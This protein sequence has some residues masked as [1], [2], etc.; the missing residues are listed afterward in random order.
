[1]LI[2]NPWHFLW[3][4]ILLAEVSTYLTTVIFCSLWLGYVPQE[5]VIVGIVDSGVVSFVVIVVVIFFVN[6]IRETKIINEQ[7]NKE[8]VVRKQTEEAL[9]E[10]EERFKTIFE[11][12]PDAY[13][14]NDL[15]GNLIDGNKASESVTGFKKEE[16]I[17]KNF[18][19]VNLVP[20]EELSK[21]AEMLAKNAEGFATGPDEVKLNRKD[22]T[23]ITVEIA[24]CPINMGAQDIILGIARD[25]TARKRAEDAL[26]ESESKLRQSQKMESIGTLAGG[27]AHDFNNILTSIIGYTELALTDVEKGSL[28]EENLQEVRKGGNRARDLV[29]QI[30][31]FARQGEKELSPIRVNHI[32]EE[33]LKLIRSTIPTSIQIE[34]N[35][36]SESSIMGDPTRIHQIFMNLCTN[37]AQ[38]MEDAGGI[39]KVS[40]TDVSLDAGLSGTL[41]SL[42]PGE[43]LELT[44]SDSGIGISPDAIESIFEPYYT[45]KEPGQG[46]GMGLAMVHGILKSHGGEIDVESEVGKGTAFKIY[47]PLTK[48][49]TESIEYKEEDLPTGSERIL[50]VDDEMQIV[51]MGCQALERLGYTVTIRASSIEALALFENKPDQFDLVITDMAMPHMTGDKFAVKLM[52]I[53]SD[54]PVILCTG[55]SKKISGEQVAEI[56]IKAYVM[57]PLVMREF[58]NTVRKVLDEAKGSIQD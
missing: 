42:K 47:L 22:G 41:G 49:D 14:L 57:K 39:L 15:D 51:Q 9:R 48:K 2:L 27:I 18:L 12:A 40:L 25:I 56:G 44:V 7:L 33:A 17:G 10:S 8:I 35:I 21:T 52:K 30:L 45:T 16:L 24:T 28:I 50:F 1:M 38:A 4:A 54:I 29:K 5:V 43:Y 3:I 31:T 32:A 34:Q 6:R 23:Q 19:E 13:Y 37:A 20:P 26:F 55:Y 46:T 58:A 36:A 53:R 11:F